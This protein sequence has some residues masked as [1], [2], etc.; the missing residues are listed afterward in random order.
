[1][2]QLRTRG[3]F[4]IQEVL[5]SAAVF[6][7]VCASLFTGALTLKKSLSAAEDFA[8]GKSDQTRLSDYLAMDLRRA[9]KFQPG[10]G[11]TIATITIPDFYDAAT[12][13]PRTPVL[14]DHRVYY[15]SPTAFSTIVYTK[16]GSSI[17]RQV[18]TAPPQEIAAHVEDF[19]VA[20][21]D[22]GKVVETQ[23]TFQPRFQWNVTKDTSA[24]STVYNTTLLRNARKDLQ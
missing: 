8:E 3:G 11:G 22:L 5:V 21:Q 14:V 16:T 12:G 18:G 7:M 19:K 20:L 1:M 24:G 10:T 23:I 9:V 4:T 2:K 6:S 13:E 17:Y 15:N